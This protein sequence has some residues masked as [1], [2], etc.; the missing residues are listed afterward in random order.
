MR[1]SVHGAGSPELPLRVL[2]LLAQHGAVV[3]RASLELRDGD[4]RISL[5]T[6]PLTAERGALL[7]AKIRAMVLVSAA[8]VIEQDSAPGAP[9]VC[10]ELVE[11]H[12][13]T[14]EPCA[15]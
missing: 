8:E 9:S 3:E 14:R 13:S 2:G 1:L 5:D 11:G 10:P 12:L 15:G 4:Y 7:L 6:A